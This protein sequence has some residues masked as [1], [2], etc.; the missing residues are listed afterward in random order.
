MY[1]PIVFIFSTKFSSAQKSDI[2]SQKHENLWKYAN[3]TS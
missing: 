2:H 3:R 1:Q